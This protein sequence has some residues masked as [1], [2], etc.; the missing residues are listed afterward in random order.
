MSDE[1]KEQGLRVQETGEVLYLLD[2]YDD[3]SNEEQEEGGHLLHENE[4]E[5]EDI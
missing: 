1:Y 5:D 4:E 3:G 2:T